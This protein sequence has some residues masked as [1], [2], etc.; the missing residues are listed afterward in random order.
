MDALQTFVALFVFALL[1]YLPVIAMPSLSPLGWAPLMVRLVLLLALAWMT[2]L[3]LPP[4]T[5][6]AHWGLPLGRRFRA[7]EPLN[8][9]AR[10]PRGQ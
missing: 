3:A 9:R 5:P 6:A 4:V 10:D 1:R 2:V 8:G 7:L